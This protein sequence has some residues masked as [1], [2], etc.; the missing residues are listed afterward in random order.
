MMFKSYNTTLLLSIDNSVRNK[1][2]RLSKLKEYHKEK[3]YN[4]NYENHDLSFINTDVN[5]LNN[6][7]IEYSKNTINEYDNYF[8]NNNYNFKA[9]KSIYN[10]ISEYK[11]KKSK[12]DDNG[13]EDTSIYD[14]HSLKQTCITQDTLFDISKILYLALK[15]GII[16]EKELES[17]CFGNIFYKKKKI[18]DAMTTKNSRCLV[19]LDNRLKVLNKYLRDTFI[20][21]VFHPKEFNVDF[22]LK[23][24]INQSIHQ[25]KKVVNYDKTSMTYNFDIISNIA[26]RCVKNK[27]PK[28]QLDL[29]NAFN[30][31]SYPFLK[32]VLNHYVDENLFITLLDDEEKTLPSPKKKE[33]LQ[34]LKNNFV[35]LFTFIVSRIKFYDENI[36]KYIKK[37]NNIK[38]EDIQENIIKEFSELSRN[39]GVP[40]GC[41]FSTDIFIM[42]M[43]YI[44]NIVMSN[45]ESIYDLKYDKD[46]SM[47]CY[48]DDIMLF[49]KSNKSQGLVNE[50][51]YTFES[52]FIKFKFKMNK[53]KTKFSKDCV[54]FMDLEKYGPDSII[55]ES[56]KFLGI[57]YEDDINKYLEYI[58]AELIIKFNQDKN[59]H[60]LKNINETIK[61]LEDNKKY[62]EL[63]KFLNKYK[64]RLRLE[65]NLRYRLSKFL[66]STSG[67]NNNAKYTKILIDNN[68]NYISRYIFN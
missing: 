65:G 35:T 3:L 24:T 38:G 20:S 11:I 21:P 32:L 33:L 52:E 58:N 63:H 42:C 37:S 5:A 59:K 68:L 19:S 48:V 44:L 31:V 1:V 51:L 28:V 66:D 30:N 10:Q 2:S 40:Q 61:N 14:I 60:S 4:S 15:K 41:S 49:L 25:A 67:I 39:K 57:Y 18:I 8:S 6:T 12:Q 27:N 9:V 22:E 46:Y 47:I 36:I 56:D 17:I 45:L 62:H 55:Q 16:L 23:N 26:N 7:E 34:Q 50:I 54:G 13:C 29:S 53:D 64:F 43:D